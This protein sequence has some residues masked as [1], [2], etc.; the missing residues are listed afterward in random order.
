[1]NKLLIPFFI[2]GTIIM[3]AV[4][5]TTGKPLKTTSTP[6]GIV[7]L[8]FAYN[9]D[10]V[11]SVFNAWGI[12]TASSKINIARTNTYW[13]FLFIFFYSGLLFL[14]SRRFSGIYRENTGFNR[15]GKLLARL[16][17]VAGV[18]DVIENGCMLQTLNGSSHHFYALCAAVCAGIKFTLLTVVVLYVFISLPL[19]A[20]AKFRNR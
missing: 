20:Y 7:N 19:S 17:I 10:K 8:E 11:D 16:A 15:A 9:K 1:M 13:D 3:I 5:L 18:L 4:M 2:L 12:N 6:G 14:A